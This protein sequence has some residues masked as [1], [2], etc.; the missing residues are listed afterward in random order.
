MKQEKISQK[1]ILIGITVPLSLV[2]AYGVLT[3]INYL[4]VPTSYSYATPSPEPKVLG[5]E[6]VPIRLAEAKPT[7]KVP[8]AK[9]DL[10]LTGVK[11]KSFLVYDPKSNMILAER[12]ADLALPVASLTKLMTGYVAYKQTNLATE[13]V[14]VSGKNIIDIS[15]VLGITAGEKVKALD[16]FNA[17]LV[18]S[19]NDAAQILAGYV[20][21]KTGTP[22]TKLMNDAA[23]ELGMNDTHFSNP[24][25][26]D[27]DT[28]Y[29]TAADLRLLVD[30]IKK[31][32]AFSLIGRETS[33][34]VITQ[35]GSK[36]SVRATNKLIKVDPEIIAIKT[37]Y[38]NEAGGAMITE[39]DHDGNS[40]IIIVL[41]SSNRETD[42]LR[43]KR[44]VIDSY[45]WLER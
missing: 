1:Q 43:L 32:Q 28:N 38:T 34:T 2:L 5:A 9:T 30:E 4:E 8:E 44:L 24:L 33:Y 6:A 29:S 27:S 18:G 39:I 15:P 14:V 36:F 25:G 21:N 31:Y 3:A 35:S 45:E 41:D 40:F 23:K 16:L 13:D 17:M 11:A 19:A 12:N 37:G 26:F 20:A 7:I 10:D 42:T 22:F